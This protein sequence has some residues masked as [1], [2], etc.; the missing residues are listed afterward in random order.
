METPDRLP[1][2]PTAGAAA[3]YVV[4]AADPQAALQAVTALVAGVG[5]ADPVAQPKAE[6]LLARMAA[7]AAQPVS[8]RAL[9]LGAGPPLNASAGAGGVVM[10]GEALDELAAFLASPDTA[11]S[12]QA[13]AAADDALADLLDA[14]PFGRA[15]RCADARSSNVSAEVR[16][17]RGWLAGWRGSPCVW[18]PGIVWCTVWC[19]QTC[20]QRPDATRLPH[21]HPPT[22]ASPQITNCYCDTAQPWPH[23][24]ALLHRWLVGTWRA[25]EAELSRARQAGAAAATQLAHPGRRLSGFIECEGLSGLFNFAASDGA[26]INSYCQISFPGVGRIYGQVDVSWGHSPRWGAPWRP[27]C[28]CRCWPGSSRTA[29]RP[30]LRPVDPHPAPPL[31]PWP[32]TAFAR[33]PPQRCRLRA[34]RTP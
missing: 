15:Q 22:P 34:A 13:A 1:S 14:P 26:C 28:S 30:W 18:L 17:R 29:V 12:L 8:T 6:A 31:C 27:S 5:S 21:I 4:T 25:V 3:S 16:G 11:R 20:R 24:D 9:G 19:C 32:L 2:F 10:D 7:P 33:R 23:C